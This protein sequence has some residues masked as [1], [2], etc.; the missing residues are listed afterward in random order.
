MA[1]NYHPWSFLGG[2]L[3]KEKLLANVIIKANPQG[4][5]DEDKMSE[6]LRK[7]Y[8]KRLDGFFHKS[9]SLLI[10]DSMHTHLAD[11]VKSQVKQTNSE[12]S[13]IPD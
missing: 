9:P 6:W 3:P 12:L 10:C 2:R 13:I 8:V 7:V 4:C 5:M 11:T 1:R